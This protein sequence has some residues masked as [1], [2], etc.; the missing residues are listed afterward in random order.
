MSYFKYFKKSNFIVGDIGPI[1][2]VNIQS[3]SQIFSRITDDITLYSYYT[4]V[5]GDRLDVISNKLY[6]TPEYYWTIILVNPHI[7]NT[8]NDL[9]KEYNADLVSYLGGKY[10]GVALKL[11]TGESLAGKFNIGE[12]VTYST[13]SGTVLGKYPTLGYINVEVTSE[14]SF[15]LNSEFTLT[16]V[17]S[18][19]TIQIANTIDMYQAP[20]HYIN[21][22]D[23]WTR[24]NAGQ[25]TAVSILDYE[26][27]IND[28][29]SQIKVIRPEKM[30]SVITSFEREMKRL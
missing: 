19:D 7:T 1:E 4:F 21:S 30:Y 26:T 17:T 5:N 15:P 20:H 24:W 27:E 8:Y 9:P 28:E 6:G 3:Y 18:G 22:D 25:V 29:N 14:D 16:G 11:A 10:P 13:Y 2:L 23:E 12:T